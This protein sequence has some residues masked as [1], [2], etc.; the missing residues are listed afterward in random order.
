MLPAQTARP[1]AFGSPSRSATCCFVPRRKQFTAGDTMRS[2]RSGWRADCREREPEVER[3]A[4]A[5]A[6]GSLSQKLRRCMRT[7]QARQGIGCDGD[8]RGGSVCSHRAEPGSGRR[9][10]RTQECRTAAVRSWKLAARGGEGA[11]GR[12]TPAAHQTRCVVQVRACL[13]RP[14]SS[15]RAPCRCA[16]APPPAA[17]LLR[18]RAYICMRSCARL[19]RRPQAGPQVWVAA[20]AVDE[21]RAPP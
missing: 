15:S 16:V 3:A 7:G 6:A 20:L 11:A 9:R 2:R 19:C 5:P 17:T 13:C 12:S 18:S 4:A 1:F 10:S 14:W 21:A 8:V